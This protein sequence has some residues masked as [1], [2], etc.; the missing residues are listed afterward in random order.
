MLHLDVRGSALENALLQGPDRL[1]GLFVVLHFI[2][3]SVVVF[4]IDKE[5]QN[6]GLIAVN[7]EPN[8]S[9]GIVEC[10]TDALPIDEVNVEGL[11]EQ[12]GD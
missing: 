1:A 6:V 10:R 9:L 8:V 2:V 5:F 3:L 4:L 11:C 7:L 12:N